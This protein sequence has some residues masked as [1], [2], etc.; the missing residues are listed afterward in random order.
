MADPERSLISK[1]IQDRAIKDTQ[2][3]GIDVEHFADPECAE[4][5]EFLVAF[6]R[7]HKQAPTSDVVKQEFPEFSPL[8][9]RNPLSYHIEN[10]I[11]HTR[12]RVA[13]ELVRDYHSAL[14]DPDEIAQIEV[15]AF[16]MARLL[17]DIVPEPRAMHFSD[18][19]RYDEY[20]RRAATGEKPGTYMGIPSFDEVTQGAQN[21]ELI[22]NVAYLGVGKSTLLRHYAYSFY[23]L[24]KTSLIITLEEEA[25]AVMRKLDSM[26]AGIKYLGMKAL[27]MDVKEKEQWKRVLDQAHKDRHDRDI[28]VRDD[29]KNCTVDRVAAETERYHP[30]TVIVDY[31]ELM[32]VPKSAGG[33]H[34]EKVA[35]SSQGLKQNARLLGV[36][37]FTASQ[38][39]RSGGKG[40]IGL[41]NISYQ[42]VGRNSD[43]VIGLRQDEEQETRQEMECI[44]LKSRDS[45]KNVLAR[46][47]WRLDEMFIREKGINERF[48]RRTSVNGDERRKSKK[49]AVAKS[50][51]E[52]SGRNP[53]RDKQNFK[54]KLKPF[55]AK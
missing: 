47:N 5:Y 30:D 31:L 54:T 19:A 6:S 50:V 1:V 21:H 13:I 26:A 37:H 35:F 12:E 52:S 2:A 9:S 23:L 27:E 39:D 8:V 11:L 14:E 40:E 38:I 32:S 48:P 20:E 18:P 22:T 45:P 15:R 16:E 34:W 10:F 41:H 3:R 46:M 51:K 28:I 44:L 36:P 43:I 33:Q 55:G 49:L 17:T 53:W 42:S 7:R 29:I 25:E 4:V 24:G